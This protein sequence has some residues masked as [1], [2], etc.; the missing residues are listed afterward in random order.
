M[1]FFLTCTAILGVMCIFTTG[2]GS[3]GN[4]LEVE[5]PEPASDPQIPTFTPTPNVT[6]ILGTWLLQRSTH[7][8]N[9]EIKFRDYADMP[10][11]YLTF[12]QNRTFQAI[13]IWPIQEFTSISYLAW[14]GLRHIEEITITFRG[15][16]QIG[17]NQSGADQLWLNLLTAEV[18]P[19]DAAELDSDFENP[20]F[21]LVGNVGAT[22]LWNYSSAE[23]GSQLELGFRDGQ[24]SVAYDYRRIK[25]E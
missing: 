17:V 2:C 4:P 24:L 25:I 23:D 5:S 18:K 16:F 22:R 13:F 15:E 7:R 12:K 11:A 20:I 21:Y 9:D 8:I 6:P 19:N 3:N 14:K 10:W 1:K